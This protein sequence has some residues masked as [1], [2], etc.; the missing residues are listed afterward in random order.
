[1]IGKTV[2]HYRVLGS[3]G[4]GGMGEVFKAEDLTL[5]RLVALKFLPQE[6][7]ADAQ[8]LERFQ[9]EARTASSLNHPHICTIYA[10][11]QH[12]GRHFIVMELLE[13]E[14]LK[15]RIEGK[16][17]KPEPLLE[18]AIHI[19]DALEAAHA[20]GIV[21]RDIKPANIFVTARGQA[22]VLDFGLAKLA[23][24][25]AGSGGLSVMDTAA[26]E[27][28]SAG[29][30]VGTVS[31]MS[32]EQARGESLD[33]RTDIFSFGA[34]LYEMATGAVPFPGTTS[35]V[36]FDGILRQTPAPPLRLNPTLPPDL[37]R[38]IAK[39]MEKER[40][41][42]YQGAAEL[43]TDLMRLKRDLDSG[44]MRAAGSESH[45]A[46][47]Q[48]PERSLAVLY[49]ENLSGAKEDE[50]F[51]DGMTEDVITELANISE[52]RVFPR[53]SVLSFRDKQVVAA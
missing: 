27:L 24:A 9:R 28:T 50:Y 40:L 52:I 2:S 34:V 33:H 49:F 21:H 48:H 42:R 26:A 29:S 51:R 17:L 43:R 44:K 30:T 11:D 5:G 3:L 16:P 1:V 38:V 46:A 23:T 22:K 8:A 39:A 15:Q 18:L 37:E 10:V 32:P 41:L 47:A 45:R 6:M 4:A 35:A 7:E 25:R 14:T 31:Y 13:G 12:E 53:S 19:A 20:R 36:V